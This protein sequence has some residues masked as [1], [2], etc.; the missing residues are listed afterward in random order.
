[1]MPKNGFTAL[2][3]EMLNH[4]N[5]K[6]KLKTSAKEKLTLELNKKRIMFGNKIFPGL[7]FFT[8][9]I[10]EF[11]DYKHGTLPYRSINMVFENINQEWYQPNSVI[12]YPNEEDFT[13]ITEFKYL[14]PPPPQFPWK[15]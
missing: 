10:D 12:N 8:G 14:T 5:I 7:L 2:V 4:R 13:R 3:R 1:M 15:Y 9:A 6:V 11:L